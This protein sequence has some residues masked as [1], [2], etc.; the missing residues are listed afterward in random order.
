MGK[1]KVG[2]QSWGEKVAAE[3]T[4][5]R[6]L[7]RRAGKSASSR[8]RLRRGAEVAQIIPL[9]KA[10]TGRELATLLRNAPRLGVDLAEEIATT[11]KQLH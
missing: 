5:R 8:R 7:T 2:L 3:V 9:P 11:L 1:E 6:K 4:R 10:R